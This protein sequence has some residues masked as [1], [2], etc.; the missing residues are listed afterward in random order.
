[1]VRSYVERFGVQT[2]LLGVA[3][4]WGWAFVAVA[5]AIELCPMYSFLA[6]RFALASLAFV[7]FYP[8]VLR[9]LNAENLRMGLIAGGLLS[10]GYILQTWGLDGAGRTTPARA[11]FITGLYVVIT[12]L[13]QAVVLK[14]RPRA[15]TL[16]GGAI[17]LAGL[18]VLSGI[19]SSAGG[20]VSGDTL[21]V[22]CAFAFTAH[23]A[24][25]GSTH[26]GH[27]VAA[28]TLV[29]LA[30][31]AAVCAVI[32]VFKEHAPIPTDRSVLVAIVVTGVFASAL[33]FVVQTWAQRELPPSRVALILVT[34]TA[35]GGLFG[36]AASPVAPPL[37]ELLGAGAMFV[38]LIVSEAVAAF[39]PADVGVTFEP[40]VE[41]MPTPV[42]GPSSSAVRS[43]DTERDS[44]L[45]DRG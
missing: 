23:I 19:G 20:W 5:D 30:T 3:V 29:Q 21:V 34:E 32:S 43:D 35:F 37:T 36:W 16:V 41:G 44:D 38:G 11:A 6:W 17:A 1:M 24:V 27:D 33:A 18:W 25:L 26:E 13:V 15:A 14:R 4:I 31:V 7:I 42:V 8:R 12:P 45:S 40:A 39:S 2:A 28:L 10:A 9:Q 22:L